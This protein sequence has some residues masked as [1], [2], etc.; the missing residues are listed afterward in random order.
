MEKNY[1]NIYKIIAL[2]LLIVG[3]VL[4]LVFA[5]V[6]D[7]NAA[8]SDNS[9]VVD[10]EV[11]EEESNDEVAVDGSDVFEDDSTSESSTY[12]EP[13][14]DSATSSSGFNGYVMLLIWA[15]F[16]L[17]ALFVFGI[18]SVCARLDVLIEKSS[19]HESKEKKK[20]IKS[21]KK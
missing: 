6:D 19:N 9:N 20:E 5:G 14:E 17:T 12:I 13:E 11:L 3:F 2:L 10:E 4:G 8:K 7:I 16:G 15:S 21:K 1:T 18:Y